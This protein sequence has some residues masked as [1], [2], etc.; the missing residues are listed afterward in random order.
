M[1]E[2]A[3]KAD[4]VEKFYELTKCLSFPD[5]PLKELAIILAYLYV[6]TER[7]IPYGGWRFP[8]AAYSNENT[9]KDLVALFDDFSRIELGHLEAKAVWEFLSKFSVRNFLVLFIHKLGIK[10]MDVVC[11]ALQK[12]YG[13]DYS[14]VLNLYLILKIN[15]FDYNQ[16]V[17]H[18]NDLYTR[19]EKTEHMGDSL[20]EEEYTCLYNAIYNNSVNIT[21]RVEEKGSAVELYDAL[22]KIATS[23]NNR[24]ELFA[25]YKELSK[26]IRSD[27]RNLVLAKEVAS[28]DVLL[29]QDS[30]CEAELE[31]NVVFGR[32]FNRQAERILIV[33]PSVEF[34]RLMDK[35]SEEV[36]EYRKSL[37]ENISK[38][39]EVYVLVDSD[40]K[41]NLLSKEFRNLIF[42]S[43]DRFL[44]LKH[45]NTFY[46]CAT[47]KK[48]LKAFEEVI[49]KIYNK[50]N[51]SKALCNVI[52][53]DKSKGAL[54]ALA[55]KY[56]LSIERIDSLPSGISDSKP[57]KKSN[58]FFVINRSQRDTVL[59]REY[60]KVESKLMS[61][62]KEVNIS[63]EYLYSGASISDLLK[64]RFVTDP[65]Y[66]K[67]VE[68]SFSKELSMFYKC[69]P[70]SKK[71]NR[72]RIIA[73]LRENLKEGSRANNGKTIKESE[74]EKILNCE[75]K[76]LIS[77]VERWLLKEYI[78]YPKVSEIACRLIKT[79]LP[80]KTPMTL[81]SFWL[82]NRHKLSHLEIEVQV[83][84]EELVFE[85]CVGTLI[86]G[87]ANSKDYE[88]AILNSAF[89]KD[90]NLYLEALEELLEFAR[91]A[92]LYD[93]NPISAIFHIRRKE[94]ADY[95]SIRSALTKKTF[96]EDEEIA[97]V[98]R[99]LKTAAS[100][101]YHLA[102]LLEIFTGLSVNEIAA[103]K[104]SSLIKLPYS[105]V[106][107]LSI[108]ETLKKENG[109]DSLIVHSKRE[110]HRK[111]PIISLVSD[112]FTSLNDSDSEY[113]L[114]H[115]ETSAPL[116]PWKVSET[117]RKLV[118][119]ELNLGEDWIYLPSRDGQ[120]KA[121]DL[122]KYYGDF[123]KSNFRYRLLNICKMDVMECDYLLGNQRKN[124]YG[125]SY[126]DF[127][128]DFMQ[129]RLYKKLCRWEARYLHN[130]RLPETK[131]IN[132]RGI[133]LKERGGKVSVSA[134]INVS[135]TIKIS[136]SSKNGV[137]GNVIVV[138]GDKDE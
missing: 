11:S 2:G 52:I 131:A 8:H 43:Y 18:F 41:E 138:R 42:Y 85:E 1:S 86:V 106:Y 110:R 79:K 3:K 129:I 99:L 56:N 82:I 96:S 34:I 60:S 72:Y 100:N 14:V 124:A 7:M 58:V 10:H 48:S 26:S 16:Y 27:E 103:L 116:H 127:S 47:D 33:N 13:S 68:V 6:S 126:C 49:K 98:N 61:L 50:D 46:C 122:N 121:T 37:K 130:T 89:L 80:P 133:H 75:Y 105:D 90:R 132:S 128:N 109:K 5:K 113:L 19:M 108:H 40:I 59:L 54:V 120:E 69:Y 70:D 74:K 91:K 117:I 88:N 95:D 44:G 57:K 107:Y 125:K 35:K 137:S 134:H 76:E 135:D 73:F 15:V 77:N 22:T 4:V 112:F 114:L 31:C 111:I 32:I 62:N 136:V 28:S 93:T 17:A 119:E 97:L 64:E 53:G 123:L 83:A 84:L 55:E 65:V 81:R 36:K 66:N 25:Q 12:K 23:K 115:S 63:I 24:L 20:S 71:S 29:V 87:E 51:N 101:S 92:K 104:K 118:K 45:I 39:F 30:I 94:K 38:S 78:L 67:A 9:Q 102:V 21:H